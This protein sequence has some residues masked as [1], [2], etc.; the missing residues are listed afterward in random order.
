MGHPLILTLDSSGAPH[1]WSSWE[2]GVCYKVKDLIAWSIGD[3]TIYYGGTSRMTGQTSSVSVPSIVAIRNLAKHTG[4]MAA[5]TNRNLFGRD[6]HM[7][8]YCGA[9]DIPAQKLTRDHIV[10]VSRGGKNVWMNVVTACKSCNNKKDNKLLSETNM[11]LLFL[12]YTPDRTEALILA[13]R[14][15]SA[16]QMEFLKSHL[17]K[18]SRVRNLQ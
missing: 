14:N 6:R 3:E 5:L 4:R 2:E 12:P 16:D 7:C 9:D 15:I 17:P 1:R 11:E 10:P 18:H 8:A 13:N